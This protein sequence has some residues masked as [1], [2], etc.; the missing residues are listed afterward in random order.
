MFLVQLFINPK[1]YDDTIE[2]NQEVFSTIVETYEEA[3]NIAKEEEEG[4]FYSEAYQEHIRRWEIGKIV[5]TQ[6]DQVSYDPPMFEV[7]NIIEPISNGTKK[8][9]VEYYN[10]RTFFGDRGGYAKNNSWDCFRAD[11]PAT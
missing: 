8:G 9:K 6:L 7:N 11:L 10:H 2:P 5:K 1:P 4:G 3:N